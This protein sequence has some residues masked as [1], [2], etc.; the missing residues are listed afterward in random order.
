M[1][2]YKGSKFERVSLGDDLSQRGIREDYNRVMCGIKR[3]ILGMEEFVM[4]KNSSVS[5]GVKKS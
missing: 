2:W 4:P 5:I 1:D 3:S